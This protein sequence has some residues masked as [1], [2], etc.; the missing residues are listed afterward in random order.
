[1]R[2]RMPPNAQKP[3]R[4]C[5][6]GAAPPTPKADRDAAFHSV[7]QSIC[8]ECRT[9]VQA[10]VLFRDGRV[11]LQKR[12]LEHGLSE[13][14][15][16]GD[17]EAWSR[18]LAFTKPGT[19]PFEAS[20]SV[21]RGCPADCGLCEDHEQHTCTPIIEI[22]N[23]CDLECPICIV[24]NRHDAHLTRAEL[25]RI[26]DT[27]RRA[28]GTVELALLS[29]GE[30]TLHPDFFELCEDALRSNVVRRLLVSSHGLRLASDE[31]FARRFKELGL[32]LSLQFDSLRDDV[33]RTLRGANLA[34]QKRR[35]LEVC[36]RLGIPTVL[37][38][39]V[40][41][42]VNDDEVGALV[43]FAFQHD[44]VTSVT[45]QPAA[46]TG[47]GGS[48]FRADP[49]SK[50]TQADLRRL[51]AEQTSWLRP[52]D[53]LPVPCSH[54]SCY[55]ACYALKDASGT[56]TPLT[57]FG[58]LGAYLDAMRNRAVIAADEHGQRLVQDAVYRLWSAQS[59][60]GDTDAVLGA[61]RILLDELGR[62][63]GEEAR[64]RAAE[65]RVKAIFVHGF[66]DED[67]LDLSRVRKCC[68]HYALPDGR[69]MPGCAYN[70][71][72]RP[73]GHEDRPPEAPLT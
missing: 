67:D 49:R 43:D 33:W 20:T 41:R 36:G 37:V 4:P 38:P 6:A 19:R 35:V 48:T 30:P 27:L 46:F 59:L 3:S 60:T 1:M 64:R 44:F 69:L 18:A 31:S 14:L 23:H 9:V 63:Q 22:T 72:H 56:L 21:A 50:L 70:T 65:G 57:R 32:Y 61:L 53:L 52:D 17:A 24:W 15:L 40:V 68:T 62:A 7:T 34:A 16:S 51:L 8:P 55:A 5:R 28:E 12:C 42:G 26:L 58:D 39:T 54:P 29:G 66:M 13:G 73:R 71:V 2:R 11:I 45:F 47:A 10:K 25:A